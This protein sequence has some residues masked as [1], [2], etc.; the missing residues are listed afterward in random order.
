M[1][2]TGSIPAL[3]L[4]VMH[5]QQL[6][7]SKP[8]NYIGGG[9]NQPCFKEPL[10]QPIDASQPLLT[11]SRSLPVPV[12]SPACIG[13]NFSSPSSK[14]AMSPETP[15]APGPISSLCQTPDSI[16]VQS[17]NAQFIMSLKL[18]QEVDSTD[19]EG[20]WF[21]A[22]VVVISDVYFRVHFVGWD[23][24]WSENISIEESVF[25]LRARRQGS[26]VGPLGPQTIK[27]IK[28]LHRCG[29]ALLMIFILTRPQELQGPKPFRLFFES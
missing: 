23:V 5:L 3:D 26:N 2:K 14:A 19:Y 20:N 1:L 16:V 15:P 8:I 4:R 28:A 7:K 13:T 10:H 25:R 22:V 21:Q 12:D 11:R 18:W 9:C 24:L 17:P 27:Q 6:Q 29:C